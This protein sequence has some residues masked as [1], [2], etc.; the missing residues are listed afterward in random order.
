MHL[1]W[2]E[3]QRCGLQRAPDS[4]ALQF[5]WPKNPV[6]M[7]YSS[8][9]EKIMHW[10]SLVLADRLAEMDGMWELGLLVH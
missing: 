3:Q 8:A 10:T 9:K 1:N 5:S 7:S 2:P 6:K 4:W